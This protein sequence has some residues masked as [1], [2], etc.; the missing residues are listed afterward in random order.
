M[1]QY[2]R[3]ISLQ[4]QRV[5]AEINCSFPHF[6]SSGGFCYLRMSETLNVII[7]NMSNE[8]ESSSR[9]MKTLAVLGF[10]ALVIFGTWLAVNIVRLVPGAFASLASLAESIQLG[11]ADQNQISIQSTDSV[12][13]S[14][15]DFTIS[16]SNLKRKGNY[17]FEFQC[18]EGVSAEIKVDGKIVAVPCNNNYVLPE[19]T[20]SI[21][22]QFVSAKKRFVDVAYQIGFI[23]DG[24]SERTFTSSKT[25]TLVNASLPTTVVTTPEPEVT[26]TPVVTTPT[27]APAPATPTPTPVKPTT[28]TVTEWVAPVSNPNGITDLA[29]KFIAVGTMSNNNLFVRADELEVGDKNAFQFEVKNIG[30][31]TSADWTFEAKLPNGE[32]FKSKLQAPLKPNERAVLTVAIGSDAGKEGTRKLTVTVKGGNDTVSSNN[33]FTT[34]VKVTD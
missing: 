8:T 28:Y 13:N 5:L 7:I 23:K 15:E 3:Q 32:T 18:A 34:S 12:V 33:S 21:D 26:P 11:R 25:I 29:T 14:E 30:T 19:D 20:F 31:K 1:I 4:V 27:P 9:L 17:T 10:V 2:R 24:E 16:W 6:Q 22:I